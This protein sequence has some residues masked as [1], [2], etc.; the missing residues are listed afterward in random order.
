MKNFQNEL[1]MLEMDQC[2]IVEQKP[3]TPQWGTRCFNCFRCNGGRP[4][5]NPQPTEPP[6]PKNMNEVD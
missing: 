3:E 2:Q 5:E 6:Q 4:Q 1:Q